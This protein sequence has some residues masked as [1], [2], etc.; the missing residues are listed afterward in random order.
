MSYINLGGANGTFLGIAQN[1]AE[2]QAMMF[3]LEVLNESGN[4]YKPRNYSKLYPNIYNSP[5]SMKKYPLM[6]HPIQ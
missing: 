2:H 5:E 4:L 3:N 6:L 1:Q